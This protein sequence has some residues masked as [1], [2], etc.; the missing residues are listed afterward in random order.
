M[1]FKY[2]LKAIEI[3]KLLGYTKP[4]QN[5]IILNNIKIPSMLQEFLNL[6]GKSSLF[7]T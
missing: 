3:L 2:N 1:K 6:V 5:T 7:S 4:T